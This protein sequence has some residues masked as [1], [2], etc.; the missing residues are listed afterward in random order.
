VGRKKRRAQFPNSIH[1]RGQAALALLHYAAL[2]TEGKIWNNGST[3][4]KVNEGKG[5]SNHPSDFVEKAEPGRIS[6]SCERVNSDSGK[7]GGR[8][9]RGAPRSALRRG[10][11]Q[12]LL[13]QGV[14]RRKGAIP[15]HS[16]QKKKERGEKMK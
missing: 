8:E 1:P 11:H 10:S 9:R 13:F 2:R 6:T 12:Q 5:K 14:E 15:L 4:S 3:L 16:F 7:E